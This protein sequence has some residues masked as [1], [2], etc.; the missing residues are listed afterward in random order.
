MLPMGRLILLRAIPKREM[1]AAMAWLSIPTLFAPLMGPPI[2]GFITT[3]YH[4]RGI[5]WL[6]VPVGLLAWCWPPRWCRRSRPR[7]CARWTCEVSSSPGWAWPW[8]SPASRWWAA[9]AAAALAWATMGLG[10]VL[11]ALY[12]HHARRSAH[13]SSISAC[14]A[15]PRSGWRWRRPAL[16]H[17]RGRDALP[18]AADAAGGIRHVGLRVGHADLHRCRRRR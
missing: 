4:W 2:G 8:P 14:C 5:F 17:R 6:N 11:L 13:P 10:G 3:Y 16:P 9:A 18:A 12:V 1:V 15:F 7:R